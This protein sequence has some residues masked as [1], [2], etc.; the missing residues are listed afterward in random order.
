MNYAH[1]NRLIKKRDRYRV[2]ADGFIPGGFNS[3]T[4]VTD[5]ILHFVQNDTRVFRMTSLLAE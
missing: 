1:T 3:L 5:E 4:A 2:G